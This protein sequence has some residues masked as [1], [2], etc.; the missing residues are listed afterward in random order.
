MTSYIKRAAGGGSFL[1]LSPLALF[2]LVHKCLPILVI[3]LLS[4]TLE[5]TQWF[6][7]L[8]VYRYGEAE[9]EHTHTPLGSVE[10]CAEIM[11]K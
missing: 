2:L 3:L 8:V 10:V 9:P 4:N 7:V 11:F 1:F 6:S 5:I